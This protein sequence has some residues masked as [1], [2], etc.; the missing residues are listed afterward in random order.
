MSNSSDSTIF[1]YNNSY[2]TTF[3][4]QEEYERELERR[5]KTHLAQLTHTP[6]FSPCLHDS[7]PNCH[8]TGRS[9]LGI[10]VHNISCQCPKCT[11]TYL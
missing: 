6:A 4:T 3:T 1:D 11:P 8:G 10:C 5:Q 9:R 7:C 2:S